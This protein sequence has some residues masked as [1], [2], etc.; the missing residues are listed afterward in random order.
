MFSIEYK[1][2]FKKDIELARKRGKD[3]NKLKEVICLLATGKELEQKYKDHVLIGKYKGRRECHISSDWLL[4]YKKEN[5][6]IVLER[7]GTHS[8]LFK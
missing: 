7:T 3:L 5:N 8:D 4:V 6:I 1:N 2:S